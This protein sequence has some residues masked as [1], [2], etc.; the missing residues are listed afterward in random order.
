MGGTCVQK[1][2]MTVRLCM[3]TVLGHDGKTVY[4]DS[5]RVRCTVYSRDCP[6]CR[7]PLLVPL[8]PQDSV[9][10][11]WTEEEMYE[12]M[13]H[14][15]HDGGVP[16]GCDCTDLTFKELCEIGKLHPCRGCRRENLE[17]EAFEAQ[18]QQCDSE[19]VCGDCVRA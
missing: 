16:G 10:P 9:S 7:K 14:I 5:L 18:C 6:G 2:S 17:P 1:K 8:R 13:C 4:F 11:Y 3:E 19:L 12:R 15:C